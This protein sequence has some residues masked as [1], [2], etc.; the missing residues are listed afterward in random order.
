MIQL[1]GSCVLESGK[2]RH[3]QDLQKKVMVID[4]PH[5]RRSVE[6]PEVR[7]ASGNSKDEEVLRIKRGT[8]RV[9]K[10]GSR[11]A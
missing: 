2:N 1:I 3:T 4:L 6:S 5:L 8:R 10:E 11:A 7:E 9:V